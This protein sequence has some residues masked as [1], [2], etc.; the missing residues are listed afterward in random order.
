MNAVSM[1][2]SDPL[3]GFRS[4]FFIPPHEGGDCVYLCGNSLGRC[5]CNSHVI[6]SI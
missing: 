6:D 1:D 2:A 5:L 3:A 4:R